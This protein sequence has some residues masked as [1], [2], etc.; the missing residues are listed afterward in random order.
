MSR[1]SKKV[2]S[3]ELIS[4][5]IHFIRGKAVMIDEDLAQLYGVETKYLNRQIKRNIER[6]PGDFMFQLTKHESLRC[7]NVT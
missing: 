7:Q 2:L 3:I 4:N 5:K 6:F 1:E